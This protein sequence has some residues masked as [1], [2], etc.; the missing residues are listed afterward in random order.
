M[1]GNEWLRQNPVSKDIPGYWREFQAELA[2]GFNDRCGWWAMY[3]GDGAVEHFLSQ[4]N[5]RHLAYEWSNYRYVAPTLNSSKKILDDAVLDPFEIQYGWFEVILPSMQLI[6]TALIP[7]RLNSKADFTLKRLQL[8]NGRKVRRLRER[9]YEDFK[10]KRLEMP[11]LEYY[12]PL[13]AEA[14]KKHLALSPTSLI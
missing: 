8:V 5:Y 13:V 12:A 9:W 10:A 14:V 7:S 4:E 3:I 11:G 1:K 2:T 6:Q